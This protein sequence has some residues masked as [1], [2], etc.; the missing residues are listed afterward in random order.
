MRTRLTWLPLVAVLLGAA[1]QD[2]GLVLTLDVVDHTGP[3]EIRRFEVTM[4]GD[5][6][7]TSLVGDAGTLMTIVLRPDLGEGGSILT[8][9]HSSRVYLVMDRAIATAMGERL[10]ADMAE[11]EAMAESL[12]PDQREAFEENLAMMLARVPPELRAEFE[13]LRG[14]ESV[15]EV[16]GDAVRPEVRETEEADEIAGYPVTRHEVWVGDALVQEAWVTPWDAVDHGQELREAQR[17]AATST[18]EITRGLPQL[19]S[20]P[21]GTAT[22]D[23]LIDRGLTVR[24]IE[25]HP[26]SGEVAMEV[27]LAGIERR[28]IDPSVFDPPDGYTRQEMMGR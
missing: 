26:V 22:A 5:R 28:E 25:Y 24:S 6:M 4:A 20:L 17:R 11:M 18:L 8:I 2:P 16:D 13:R 23:D 3:P 19:Q 1:P 7:A 10:I 9:D 21:G 14:G 12:P 15:P 27:T